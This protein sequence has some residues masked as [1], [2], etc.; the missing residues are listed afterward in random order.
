VAAA[1]DMCLNTMGVEGF[2][3]VRDETLDATEIVSG[4]SFFE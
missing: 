1:A 4:M 3:V 2:M